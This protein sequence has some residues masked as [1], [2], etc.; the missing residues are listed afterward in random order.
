MRLI[1][2]WVRATTALLALT[3]MGCEPGPITQVDSSEQ[4]SGE[5][6]DVPQVQRGLVTIHASVDPVDSA[7]ADSLGWQDGVPGV[8]IDFLRNG[9]AEWLTTTTDST[10]TASFSKVLPGLYRLFGG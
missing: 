7:L 4:A 6:S 5:G 8:E 1:E 10:G 9:T 2:Y 3:V